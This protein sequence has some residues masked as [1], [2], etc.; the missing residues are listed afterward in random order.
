MAADLSYHLGFDE[1]YEPGEQWLTNP[2]SAAPQ[3]TPLDVDNP[4]NFVPVGP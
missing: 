2:T 4:N 3:P 1:E